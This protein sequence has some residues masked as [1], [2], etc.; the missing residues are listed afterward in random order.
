MGA[1]AKAIALPGENA[2]QRYPAFP[3]LERS[4]VLQF[5]YTTMGKVHAGDTR[6]CLFRDAVYPL[7]ME[8]TNHGGYALSYRTVVSPTS[9]SITAA[10][11][12][13]NVSTEVEWIDQPEA[14]YNTAG[15]YIGLTV[16]GLTPNTVQ[17]PILG[18]DAAT[19]GLNWMYLSPQ[20]KL[21]V[22][23]VAPNGLVTYAA[24][25]T[26]TFTVTAYLQEWIAPG[27]MKQQDV[28]THTQAG[29]NAPTG[30]KSLSFTNLDTG[31][32]GWFRLSKVV[33]QTRVNS[34][35]NTSGT[36]VVFPAPSGYI[37][38]ELQ[39][40][41]VVHTGTGT[42]SYET[43]GDP[44]TYPVLTVVESSTGLTYQP[45]FGP[46]EFRN[47]ML[48]WSDTRVTACSALFTNVTKTLNKEGT[49]K[50]G[51]IALG[52]GNLNTWDNFVFTPDN[53]DQLHPM[54]RAFMGLQ[55]GFYT[56]VAP[57][58]SATEFQNHVQ[59]QHRGAQGIYSN[60]SNLPT[61]NLG[62]TALAHAMVFSDPDGDTNLAITLDQH[63]EFRSTSSLFPIG[64]STITMDQYQVA[65][66]ALSQV[67]YFF[68][69]EGHESGIDRVKAITRTVGH[70]LGRL[71]PA[72]GVVNPAIGRVMGAVG[73]LA[74]RP[75]Q[76]SLH[77]EPTTVETSVKRPP[78]QAKTAEQGP[79]GQQPRPAQQQ[80]TGKGNKGKSGK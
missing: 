70:W 38:S 20:H 52:V 21:A 23:L 57:T 14:S 76:K 73:Q 42:Y 40:F 18:T 5:R 7:W 34:G 64:M 72:V 50:A 79:K 22:S 36:C 43:A 1:V 31:G 63:L 61:F 13:E 74:D 65:C 75:A 45:V 39:C 8:D 60:G 35:I 27:K 44:T 58:G 32:G 28:T 59:N 53:L 47:S 48:P 77:V 2:P 62:S 51:R 24:G 46:K 33:I 10:N 37:N 26:V 49:V 29:V 54:E 12:T 17:T 6:A 41:I 66:L 78:P 25:T 9:V 56:Y 71:A 68:S 16:S 67:G 4:S 3:S 69:N 55:N 19:G 11:S 15:D 80:Q 30:A